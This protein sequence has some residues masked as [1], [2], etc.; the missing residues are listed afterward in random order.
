MGVKR[1]RKKAEHRYLWAIILK[2]AQVKV[3]G[4]CAKRRRGLCTKVN[5]S[6]FNRSHPVVCCNNVAILLQSI[7]QHVLNQQY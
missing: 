6:G 2:E 7:T 4:P 5:Y 3:Y 1:W